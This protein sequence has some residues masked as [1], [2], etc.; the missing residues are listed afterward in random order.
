MAGYMNGYKLTIYKKDRRY[1]SGER[2]VNSYFYQGY[3]HNAMMNEVR[4]LQQELYKPSDGWRLF[5]KY[6]DNYEG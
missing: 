2:F 1:K 6:I 3:K 4:E 5:V